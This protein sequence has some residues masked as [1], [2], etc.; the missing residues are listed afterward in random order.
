MFSDQSY[1]K[2][3]EELKAALG[4]RGQFGISAIQRHLRWGY[5]RASYL[6]EHGVK[7]GQLVTCGEFNHQYMFKVEDE[8]Q[9]L[10]GHVQIKV[11]AALNL[12]DRE[13]KRWSAHVQMEVETA[14]N[15]SDRELKQWFGD[16]VQGIRAELTRL[17]ESGRVYLHTEGC[18]NEDPVT[19]KCL[20]HYKD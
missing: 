2:S 18:D 9:A 19:G 20:R 10:S 3:L 13:L 12:S 5:N 14:L 8:K 4:S 15:L 11:E 17:K 6:A 7:T 16:D 1:D